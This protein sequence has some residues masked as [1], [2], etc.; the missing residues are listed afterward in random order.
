MTLLTLKMTSNVDKNATIESIVLNN[1]Y[2]DPKLTRC[3]SAVAELLVH[4]GV[5]QGQS[6]K[7]WGDLFKK[8]QGSV[9]SNRIGMK[10]G[11]NVL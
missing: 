6:I 5:I 11:M 8:G 3:F 4:V 9:V 2:V 7:T 1:A 10:F